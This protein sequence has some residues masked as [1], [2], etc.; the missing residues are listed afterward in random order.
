MKWYTT[1]I[2]N[3]ILLQTPAQILGSQPTSQLLKHV[4]KKHE[5]TSKK[6]KK[7]LLS[8][9]HHHS[10]SNTHQEVGNM[11][12]CNSINAVSSGWVGY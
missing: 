10:R 5:A 3:N 4:S 6:I 1:M 11:H 2:G 12:A 8:N 7:I 9:T